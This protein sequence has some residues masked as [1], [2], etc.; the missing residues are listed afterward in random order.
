MGNTLSALGLAARVDQLER[1]ARRWRWGA[2]ALGS[3]LVAGAGT[4]DGPAVVPEVRTRK[5]LLVDD[6]DRPCAVLQYAAGQA[7]GLEF[8][9]PDNPKNITSI[10]GWATDGSGLVQVD[11][12]DGRPVDFH[13]G[14]VGPTGVPL[15]A[16]R[17]AL[18]QLQRR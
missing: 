2:I 10:I 15:E 9:D 7:C 3:L 16:A 6:K 13:V 5:L 18:E 14:S 12:K 17:K 1:S 11:T 4:S 8:V